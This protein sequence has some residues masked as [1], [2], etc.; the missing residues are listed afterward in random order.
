MVKVSVC[1][2]APPLETPREETGQYRYPSDPRRDE[3]TKASDHY[4]EVS[5]N[6]AHCDEPIIHRKPGF[7]LSARNKAQNDGHGV[8][9]AQPNTDTDNPDASGIR[10]YHGQRR[11]RRVEIRSLFQARAVKIA[12]KN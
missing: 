9:D 8:D 12:Q 2:P 7:A 3:F 1:L 11:F 5:G 4:H 10:R 6:E